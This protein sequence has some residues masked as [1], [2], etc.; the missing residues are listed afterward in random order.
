MVYY[1]DTPE[2]EIV[3]EQFLAKE[4]STHLSAILYSL[5]LQREETEKEAEPA[6]QWVYAR[7]YMRCVHLYVFKCMHIC[8]YLSVCIYV[9]I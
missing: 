8:T 2:F 1:V 5:R 3:T 6:A 9:C 7:V 4:H